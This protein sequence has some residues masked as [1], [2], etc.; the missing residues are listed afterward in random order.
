[1]KRVLVTTE[2]PSPTALA[3]F[4]LLMGFLAAYSSAAP[5]LTTCQIILVGISPSFLCESV[6]LFRGLTETPY[7][8]KAEKY[9]H[10]HS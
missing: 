4:L 9:L 3:P 1:M 6:R 2:R 7:L 8:I 5:L 10:L